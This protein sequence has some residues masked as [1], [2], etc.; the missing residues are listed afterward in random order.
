MTLSP[1]RRSA[2]T[3]QT[4]AKGGCIEMM[5]LLFLV[6]KRNIANR[7]TNQNDKP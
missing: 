6:R 2:A 3:R 1:K 4:I 5:Q 7:K